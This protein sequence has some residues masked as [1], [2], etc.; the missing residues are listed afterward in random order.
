VSFDIFLQA[1]ESGEAVPANG[2]AAMSVL[3]PHIRSRDD[4]WCRITLA[5]GEA[6]VFGVAD[7]SSGLMFNHIG[8]ALAWD[9]IVEVAR[10]GR[11]V[12]MPV[13]CSTCV[14]SKDDIGDVPAGLDDGAIV[15]GSGADLIQVV[16]SR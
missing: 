2:I 3:E 1:F 4:D 9:V 12:I 14:L 8:G 7:P 15:I 10:H 13:G 6:D 16:T 5:D 11:F